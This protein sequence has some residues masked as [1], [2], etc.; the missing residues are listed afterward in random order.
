MPVISKDFKQG[1]QNIP[2]QELQKLV[3]KLARSN[4]DVYDLINIGYLHK[5]DLNQYL[6]ILHS[7]SNHIDLIFNLPDKI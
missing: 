1:V 6:S 3:L 7:Q 2:Y 4:R 5:E